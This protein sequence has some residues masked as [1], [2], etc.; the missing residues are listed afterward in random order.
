MNEIVDI[1]KD[2]NV[3]SAVKSLF[4]YSFTILFVP[5]GSMFFLKK[6]F[7]EGLFF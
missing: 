7:F 5:L 1:F 3:Q 6:F 2:K 4:I